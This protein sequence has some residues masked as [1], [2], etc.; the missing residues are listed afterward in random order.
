MKSFRDKRRDNRPHPSAKSAADVS[1]PRPGQ[2]PARPEAPPR[3]RHEAKTENRSEP[4]SAPRIPARR[5]GALPAEHLPVILEV[6]PNADY[7]LLDSGTGQKLE[8][9]G[10]YRIVRPEGQAIW[11]K[12]LPAKEWERAD[13][14]FTGD[15]DEE[16]IGRWRFPKLPLGETWPMKHD[17]ID[18]L[19]RFTSFRHVG[20]FP[21]QASHWDHMAGLIA[22]AKRPVKVLN[23]FGYTGL[24]SLVA[25]SAGAEVTH[26][27]ASKKAIGW[28]RE[29]QEMAGLGSKPIRWIVDD[30][31][32][33][34]ER[35]ERR[36]SRYDIILFDPPAYG[37]GPKGEVWQ[38]FEDLPDLTDLCRAILTPKP[39][40]VVLTAYSIRASFFAIH[41]L[42]RDTFAGMG[43]KVESGELII[44]EKSAGR[45]LSTSLFSRWVAE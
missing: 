10:P 9:Y 25:A 20:V 1:R 6:A 27:D 37:R 29:N 7:A 38:L 3:E 42:M 44:R 40:A 28:A 12:A 39:L 34:A 19:G 21:E 30:A 17:G 14:V 15:T 22:A 11:Q 24:A 32:K 35:E 8:Q 26:V 33:F 5:E 23:L 41:A 4:N 18:Y 43:G 31:V 36:G 16:G 13:A 45:A 2:A